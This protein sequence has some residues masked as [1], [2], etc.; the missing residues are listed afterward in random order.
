M[1]GCLDL[2]NFEV[3]WLGLNLGFLEC[4]VFVVAL[5]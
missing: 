4:V 1:F 5:V 3:F 2:R